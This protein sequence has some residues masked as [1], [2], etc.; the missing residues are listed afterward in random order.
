VLVIDFEMIMPGY[1]ESNDR[2]FYGRKSVER[3]AELGR[4][5][6]GRLLVAAEHKK[7]EEV[8]TVLELLETKY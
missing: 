6:E 1:P 5:C 3:L 4:Q 2:K 8:S 7:R